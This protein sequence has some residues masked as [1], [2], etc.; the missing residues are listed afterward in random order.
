[1][2]RS[3]ACISTEYMFWGISM[4]VHVNNCTYTIQ[5]CKIVFNFME[6][7][8]IVQDLHVDFVC[9]SLDAVNNWDW[10]KHN[11]NFLVRKLPL[12]LIFLTLSNFDIDTVLFCLKM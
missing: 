2:L 7:K 6:H 1:M 5:F 12:V 4:C 9:L 8:F 10:D 11:H 3:R